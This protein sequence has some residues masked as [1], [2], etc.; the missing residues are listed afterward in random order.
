MTD[1][2]TTQIEIKK[3]AKLGRPS[4]VGIRKLV[5]SNHK[6]HNISVIKYDD[7]SVLVACPLFGW[8]K[9]NE[10]VSGLGCVPRKKR[11]TW[12]ISTH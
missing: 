5:C 9:D 2:K 10:N 3:K 1:S 6:V 4:I 12:Y 8:Y 11:C 7:E